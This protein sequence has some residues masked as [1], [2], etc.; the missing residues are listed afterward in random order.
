MKIR[1]KTLI[2][3]G[4]RLAVWA[5]KAI[6]WTCRIEE[7]EARPKLTP[8]Q[9]TD[10]KFLYCIWHDGIV[11]VLFSGKQ[12]ELAGLTSQ[13][14]DGSVVA[15]TMEALDI[16]QVRG[17]SGKSGVAAIRQIKAMS[18]HH[19]AI[20][21]DGPRGPRREVKDGITYIAS[22]TGRK[23]VP[24][25]FEADRAW[26]VR[27]KWSDLTIPKPFSRVVIAAGEPIEVPKKLR[28]DALTHWTGVIEAASREL[29][30]DVE[31]DL[32]GCRREPF[33]A[34]VKRAA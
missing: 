17:S 28:G 10:E 26:R 22:V 4:V 29:S 32:L 24:V 6:F 33:R 7:R 3:G 11:G 15:L 27:A 2:R 1:N 21:V 9:M 23:V 13:S 5:L 30:A 18:D 16:P 8:F 25:A 12:I 20:T 34:R 31:Q 14:S 19:M